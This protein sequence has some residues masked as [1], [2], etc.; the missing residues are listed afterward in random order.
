MQER[1]RKCMSVLL[2][3]QKFY[4]SISHDLLFLKLAQKGIGNFYFLLKNMYGSCK[5]AVN[6]KN[7]LILIMTPEKQDKTLELSKHWS[8][9]STAARNEVIM[10]TTYSVIP[11]K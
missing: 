10:K 4:D 11:V 3:L 8:A 7:D 1:D 9:D 6:R 5:Y 2:I